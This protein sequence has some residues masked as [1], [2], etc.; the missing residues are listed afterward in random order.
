MLHLQTNFRTHEQRGAFVVTKGEGVRVFDE[1]G[2]GYIEGMAGLWCTSLGFSKPR[3]VEAAIRQMAR[4][5]YAHVYN[6]Q[7]HEPAV[8]LAERIL[9]LTPV[10]MSKVFFTNSG[11]EAND[12]IV[13]MV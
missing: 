1:N 6:H 9:A 11:S 10:P 5:P 12:S 3:L 7:T 2:K 13:R 8:K 4:L